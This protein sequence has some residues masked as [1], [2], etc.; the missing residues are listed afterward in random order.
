MAPYVIPVRQHSEPLFVLLTPIGASASF[1]FP[2]REVAGFDVVNFL[3]ISNLAFQIRVEEASTAD[4]PWTPIT[5]FASAPVAGLQQ[6]CDRVFPCGRFM[7]VFLDNLAP[8]LQSTLEFIGYGLPIFGSG[9]G[10]GSQGTQGPQGTN[11]GVQGPQG[12]QGVAGSGPQG[13]QGNSGPQGNQ[14]I[15]GPQG[16]QGAQGAQG[17]VPD[18]GAKANHVGGT[19]LPMNTDVA[20]PFTTEDY[21]TGVPQF[22][23]NVV[24]NTRFTAPST[25]KY[26]I[27]FYLSITQFV[28]ELGFQINGA[29]PLIF[30]ASAGDQS[31]MGGGRLNMG[32][33]CTELLLNAGD[34]VEF[35][36]NSW[37]APSTTGTGWATIR[38]VG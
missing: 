11:P 25:G 5:T 23:D 1:Q 35:F 21:D 16:N 36:G 22:H 13:N 7:R 31:N 29:G 6:V 4:G 33:F 28:L 14:G 37:A 38:K 3:A 20:I 32:G 19:A 15:S 26:L 24:N 18:I 30:P 12:F 34:Y 17:S 8:S 10:G 27:S 9:G 2:V